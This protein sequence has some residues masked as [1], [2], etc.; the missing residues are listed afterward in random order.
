MVTTHN[1]ETLKILDSAR[2]QQTQNKK[3]P[4][5]RTWKKVEGS[6]DLDSVNQD[7]C[8]KSIGK[9]LKK[10]KKKNKAL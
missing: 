2:Y 6:S 4:E 9:T 10:D 1:I 7:R 3:K 8:D 5:N